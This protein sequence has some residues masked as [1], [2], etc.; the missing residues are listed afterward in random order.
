[1]KK[2]FIAFSIICSAMLLLVGCS[3]DNDWAFEGNDNFITSFK[4]LLADS[5]GGVVTG[6]IAEGEI[7]VMVPEDFSF[8]GAQATV[9][10]SEHATIYPNPAEITNWDEDQSFVV[11]SYNGSQNIY[12]YTVRREKIEEEKTG[13]FVLFSQTDVNNFAA[14]GIKKLDGNLSVGIQSQDYVGDDMTDADDP[15]VTLAPLASLTEVKGEIII[16]VC[17]DDYSVGFSNLKKVGSIKIPQTKY[18]LK[19]FI[20]PSLEEVYGDLYYPQYNASMVTTVYLPKLVSVGG[21][22]ELGGLMSLA[23]FSVPEL[24]QVMGKLSLR[25]NGAMGTISTLSFPKLEQVGDV[26]D[27]YAFVGT[28]I[29]IPVLKTCGGFDWDGLNKIESIEAPALEQLFGSSNFRNGIEV[30][31]I[32]FPKITYIEN[33]ELSGLRSLEDI[34]MPE[35]KSAKNINFN[36]LVK[37]SN[38]ECLGTLNEVIETLTLQNLSGLTESF[39]LPTTLTSIG[40]L[41]IANLP[42]LTELD[43]RDTGIKGVGIT[44]NSNTPFKLTADD[45]M[46]GSLSLNGLFEL[47]G[48]KEVK[49]D[50]EIIVANTNTAVELIPNM[51]TVHGNFTLTYNYTTGSLNIPALTKVNGICRINTKAIV[52]MPKFAEA[53][54]DFIYNKGGANDTGIVPEFTLPK[55]SKINGDFAIYIGHT[56]AGLNYPQDQGIPFDIKMPSLTTITG[57]LKIHTHE[58]PSTSTRP[59]NRLANL[60]GFSTLEKVSGVDIYRQAALRNYTGLKKALTSFSAD[61]WNLANIGYMPSYDDLVKDGKY[62]DPTL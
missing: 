35:L 6:A 3:K 14:L 30:T 57:I 25:A 22:F 46:E 20:F 44:S 33:I 36:S 32:S 51:E 43:I 37:L 19:D 48:M 60:D 55:L 7:I 9:A 23:S 16:Y 31:R 18:R 56:M 47:S 59:S 13:N 58:N 24:K 26:M 11:S 50:V 5:D 12:R 38:L 2:I 53:G 27:L 4:L 10:I 40:K 29:E 42:G 39:A 17:P 41:D 21:N 52:T 61:Y 54:A 45:I 62:I 49:G 28:S 8:A 34:D 15:I 1:M